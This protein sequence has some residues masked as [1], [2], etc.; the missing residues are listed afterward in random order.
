METNKYFTPDLSEMHV[1]CEFEMDDTWGGWMKLVLT[2]EL[3]KHPMVSLGSGNE[4]TPWYH[5]FRV[6]YLTKEQIEAE[7]WEYVKNTA[8]VDIDICHIFNKNN[9]MLGWF[10]FINRIALLVRDPSRVFDDRGILI[11]YHNTEKYTGECKDIN[12]FRTIC[13]LLKI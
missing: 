5:K 10:P 11:E 8:T 2:E 3:L 4:R 13:K 9:Y 1:G 7:G 12:T 6:S